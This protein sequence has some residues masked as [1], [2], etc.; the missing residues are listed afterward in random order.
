MHRLSESIL[1]DFKFSLNE[2]KCLFCIIFL[3]E[4]LH[5]LCGQ[6]F[7]VFFELFV[8]FIGLLVS[9]ND[10]MNFLNI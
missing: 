1:K 4:N 5:T 9:K 10:L 8:Q 7:H 3:G 6:L 2:V